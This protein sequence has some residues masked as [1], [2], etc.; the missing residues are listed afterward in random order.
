[1]QQAA[2][3]WLQTSEAK[4]L[5]EIPYTGPQA[6]AFCKRLRDAYLSGYQDGRKKENYHE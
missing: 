3:Q 2:D 4:C 1:M 5:A 6:E